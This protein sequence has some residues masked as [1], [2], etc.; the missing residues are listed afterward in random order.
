MKKLF[1]ISLAVFFLVFGQTISVQ[2]VSKS[3]TSAGEES[4]NFFGDP[5]ILKNPPNADIPAALTPGCYRYGPKTRETVITRE[6]IDFLSKSNV[7]ILFEECAVV[8]DDA[9]KIRAL[10]AALK[11]RNLNLKYIGYVSL[12]NLGQVGSSEIDANHEEWFVHRKGTP[13]TRGNRIKNRQGSNILNITNPAYQDFMAAKI[14]DSLERHYMGGTFLDDVIPSMR[15][16]FY[17]GTSEAVD[18]GIINS[19]R[20]GWIDMVRKVKQAAGNKLIFVAGTLPVVEDGRLSMSFMREIMAY[21]DGLLVERSLGSINSDFKNYRDMT[22]PPNFSFST[23]DYITAIRDETIRLNKYLFFVV[24]SG[25][26]PPEAEATYQTTTQERERR[27]ARY[28]LAAFL[29][30]F[31]GNKNILLYYPPTSAVSSPY[32]TAEAYFTDW[33]LKIGQPTGDTVEVSSGVWKRSFTNAHVYWNSSDAAYM[34]DFGQNIVQ[35]ADGEEI[36]RYVLPARSGMLFLGRNTLPNNTTTPTSS[37]ISITP[38]VS[39][40]GDLD[41]N[42]KVDIFDYNLIIENFGKAGSPG[43]SSA[44][45]DGNGKVDIFD[46]NM[47]VGNFGKT[48]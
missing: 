19:W 1:A 9:P 22:I 32:F 30:F 6:E 4:Y 16:G 40:L 14:A 35:T 28:Y 25:V 38:P 34:V 18:D 27:L 42:N 17:S 21:A 45:I 39:I 47:L 36:S 41:H 24:N 23:Y 11:E 3:H 37:P 31:R 13:A 44:D 7:P 46:Y 48:S 15:D 5:W 20:R 29:N 33:D 2:A 43:F 10:G 12:A 8:Q 26:Q